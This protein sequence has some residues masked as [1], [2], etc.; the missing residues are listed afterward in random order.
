SGKS[1]TA[2]SVS[3]ATSLH[4]TVSMM[5][6]SFGASGQRC[7]EKRPGQRLRDISRTNQ[8][9]LTDFAPAAGLICLVLADSTPA[10]KSRE[11]MAA[12][13]AA[14]SRKTRHFFYSRGTGKTLEN[15][16]APRFRTI[17]VWPKGLA[18]RSAAG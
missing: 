7:V 13:R 11:L 15:Q 2:R 16:R 8:A 17:Q 6:P 1:H 18:G 14:S 9:F 10:A 4:R 12:Y 3:G 5:L